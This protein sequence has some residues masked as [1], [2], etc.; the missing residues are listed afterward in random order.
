MHVEQVHHKKSNYR[1]TDH[2]VM[3]LVVVDLLALTPAEEG[4]LGALVVD[5]CPEVLHAGLRRRLGDLD[6]LVDLLLRL[7]VEGLRKNCIR[8]ATK[9]WPAQ[10][11]LSSCSLATP[12]S[13]M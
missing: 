10:H 3:R 2:K 9:R 12:H 13:S 7:L 4:G 11:T 6:R 5:I 8:R 1:Q